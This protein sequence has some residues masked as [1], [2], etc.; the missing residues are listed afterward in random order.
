MEEIEGIQKDRIPVTLVE[1][2]SAAN[3]KDSCNSR[4]ALIP[5]VFRWNGCQG[6]EKMRQGRCYAPDIGIS[7]LIFSQPPF[8]YL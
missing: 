1:T 8:P 3:S 6:R 5:L 7:C 4:R 2:P